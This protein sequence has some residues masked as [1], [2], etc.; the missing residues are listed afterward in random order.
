MFMAM[1][2]EHSLAKD[3]NEEIRREVRANRVV[4]QANQ[5]RRNYLRFVRNL[6]RAERKVEPKGA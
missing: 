5:G 2:V 3:R 4:R 1:D 6:R